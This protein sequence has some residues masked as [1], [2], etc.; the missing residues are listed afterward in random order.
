MTYT[1]YNTDT[2]TDTESCGMKKKI[3]VQ[4]H[5]G[6]CIVVATNRFNLV[7]K[8]LRCNPTR[9]NKQNKNKRK[10]TKWTNCLTIL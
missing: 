7:K 5:D 8:K 6:K 2:D 10:E 1:N 3:N 9:K 4:I